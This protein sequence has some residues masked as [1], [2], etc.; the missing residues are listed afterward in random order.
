MSERNRLAGEPSPYLAQ[1]AADPVAWYPWGPEAFAAAAEADKPMLLSIGYSSCHWCH[2]MARESFR[3]PAVA[4]LLNAEFVSVKVDREERPDVDAVYLAAVQV[5][6]GSGGWPLTVIATPTGRPFFGGTYFPPEDGLGA[7][8]FRRVLDAMV[9][10]WRTRRADV[11][12][13][14]A[15]LA[16]ALVRLGAAPTPLDD[17]VAADALVATG[18]RRLRQLEDADEGGFGGAPKF[19]AHEAV[20]LLLASPDEVDRAVAL[21]A[22]D[23]MA[24]GGVH[25]LL[26]G[27]FFRYAVDAA[28]RVPHFEK[29]LY[30]NAALLRAYA[31]AYRLTG[32]E[33]HRLAAEGIVAWLEGELRDPGGAFWCALDAEAGGR[34][35]G[36][37]LWTRAELAAAV[38]GEVPNGRLDLVASGLGV[39]PAD[40]LPAAATPRVAVSAAELARRADVTVEEVED[41][42]ARARRAM[43][44]ARRRRERP[45]A[46]A[47]V[48]TSW[49][50]LLVAALADAATDLE[51]PRLVALAGEVTAALRSSV[52]LEG[53]LW[54]SHTAGERRVE[55]LLEDYAY[56]GL[57]LLALHRATLDGAHLSW[58]LE[59][60]D[61]V[62]RRFA[63]EEGGG[64]FNTAA[65]AEPL[66][67][68]PKG[69]VDGATPSEYVAAAELVWWAA[70]C[71][72]D[73]R[74]EAGARAAALAAAASAARE[75][76]ALASG[77]ALAGLQARPGREVVL[78]G[79]PGDPA[80]AELALA[81]R[82]LA[83]PSD[84]VLLV[85][86]RVPALTRL[87]LLEG[88]LGA[89]AGG[90]A[91]AY[92]CVRGAC[93][94]PVATAAALAGQ[95]GLPADAAG[96]PVS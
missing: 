47:K 8:S 71:R 3:D 16:S 65:D 33:R 40:A 6:T 77:L 91:T 41:L 7:P 25:D 36:H 95:L 38:A 87:P 32:A 46:D 44:A 28:W 81:A 10:A 18:T 31:R 49:N 72:S 78:V 35:G 66:L 59:L 37:Y 23:A 89:L 80:L 29:M 94:L 79:R 34:E 43:L 76:L 85:D 68:R 60:A 14:A 19:P 88:R 2:V 70:R 51:R 69:L 64:W 26:G 82:R 48:L 9:V 4:A 67:V 54:H 27:G 42:L 90:A 45:A 93:R 56:L 5:M 39:P 22:L 62:T 11:E 75:P 84:L 17:A 52:W 86:G 30:D 83:G 61:V 21:R 12:A 63:D 24:R 96:P 13:A 57:G 92:V 58:A 15:D 74:A 50:G 20:R 73:A 53:R 1:H 55:G